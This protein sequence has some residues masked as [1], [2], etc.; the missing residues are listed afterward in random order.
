LQISL[1]AVVINNGCLGFWLAKDLLALQEAVCLI[2]I[3]KC[4]GK[5]PNERLSLYRKMTVFLEGIWFGLK[6]AGCKNLM[7]DFY[8]DIKALHSMKYDLSNY[9]WFTW[10]TTRKTSHGFHRIQAEQ[11]SMV[12]IEYKL[13]NCPWF[14]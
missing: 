2:L 5:R 12:S 1:V 14:P 3:V 13:N 8:E 9:S 10:N 11:L 7:A 6:G 4:E